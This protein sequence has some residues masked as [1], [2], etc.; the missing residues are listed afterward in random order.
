MARAADW[1]DTLFLFCDI[2][3]NICRLPL[4]SALSHVSAAPFSFNGWLTL[5]A[6][7][8]DADE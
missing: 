2:V 7:P 4:C 6:Q 1:L 5:E 3:L 8:F